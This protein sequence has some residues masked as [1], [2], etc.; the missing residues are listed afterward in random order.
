MVIEVCNTRCCRMWLNMGNAELVYVQ[1]HYFLDED[2]PITMQ[3]I[4]PS[5]VPTKTAVVSP[6]ALVMISPLE[7][8]N[9]NTTS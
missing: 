1:L 7:S 5:A 3:I 9:A 2:F 8:P 6:S 4:S